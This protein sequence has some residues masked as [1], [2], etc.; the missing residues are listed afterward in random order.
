MRNVLKMNRLRTQPIAPTALDQHLSD[1]E[2]FSIPRRSFFGHFYLCAD[3]CSRQ[4]GSAAAGRPRRN[5]RRPR[6]PRRSGRRTRPARRTRRPR[7]SRRPRR[8]RTRRPR[9][10]QRRLAA[11][12]EA[13]QR[14]GFHAH[15][16]GSLKRPVSFCSPHPLAVPRGPHAGGFAF[17]FFYTSRSMFRHF[18]RSLRTSLF[19]LI[20]V[21]LGLL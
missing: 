18:L 8:P 4:R 9:P 20:G 17:F 1:R 12:H 3:L 7:R 15:G 14:S 2:R 21:L 5:G 11:R 16:P 6:R 10:L 13:A 19:E